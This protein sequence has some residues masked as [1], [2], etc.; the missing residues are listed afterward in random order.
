[1]KYALVEC[2]KT[3]QGEGVN[4]GRSAI[5]VRF[6]GCNLWTGRDEHRERDAERTGAHC[7]R[8]CDTDFVVRERV[9]HDELVSKIRALLP[10]AM[11]VFSGGE[12]FLQ[13]TL[14]LVRDCKRMGLFT[15]IETNGLCLPDPD[16]LYEL[17]HV[18]VS[19]KLADPMIQVRRGHELKVV[20]PRYKPED[21]AE[22]SRGF[23][24]KLV[25]PE[26]ATSKVGKSLT[27]ASNERSAAQWCMH[28]P[29]WRLSLQMH[30]HLEIP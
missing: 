12:P 30:K 21:Y 17:E 29:T 10:A 14:A 26:A 27:V 3:L 6:A 22:L 2:F 19:P 5:F 16:L 13:L 7:P 1:M 8:F 11:V 24:H 23:M 18:C 4:A 15:C 25:S 20:W 28:N 9:E